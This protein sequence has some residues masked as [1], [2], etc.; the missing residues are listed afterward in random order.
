MPTSDIIR[1]FLLSVRFQIDEAGDRKFRDS[2]KRQEDAAV[3]TKK[4]HDELERSVKNLGLTATATAAT[5]AAGL[6]AV[7]KNYEQLYYVARRTGTAAED[8]TK[9]QFGFQQI[10][11][12]AGDASGLIVTLSNAIKASP[13][14]AGVFEGISGDRIRDAA[15]NIRITTQALEDFFT[16]LRNISPAVRASLASLFGIPQ[17]ELE[18]IIAS[19]DD[20]KKAISDATD[21]YR[22][23][24]VDQDKFLSDSRTITNDLKKIW[25]EVDIVWI[26][27]FEK[28]FPVADRLLKTIDQLL[29]EYL[30]FGTQHPLLAVSA[31]A[32]A[33]AIGLG[34]VLKIAQTIVSTL[35]RIV[36]PGA[37]GGAIGRL[38]PGLPGVIGAPLALGAG[39]ATFLAP[40][41]AGNQGELDAEAR[42][43]AEARRRAGVG[44]VFGPPVPPGFNR[45]PLPG[46]LNYLSG[47]K[48][49][50]Q[51]GV[52]PI[53]AHAGEMVLPRN[54]SEGLQQTYGLGGDFMKRSAEASENLEKELY[55]WLHGSAIFAPRVV[56]TDPS[57]APAGLST[58][59]DLLT[60]MLQSPIG[61]PG[62]ELVPGG[63]ADKLTAISGPMATG[64]LGAIEHFESGG[65]NVF[66]YMYD[67]LHTASG[68][69]QITNST[70]RRYAPLVTGALERGTAAINYSFETQ[71]DVADQILKHEGVGPWANY[72]SRLRA[73]LGG[74]YT[75]IRYG[76]RT[77]NLTLNNTTNIH[78]GDPAEITAR[79]TRTNARLAAD[80]LRN[81]QLL[82]Y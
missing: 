77:A 48:H 7:A 18:R 75:G 19:L 78:G 80:T 63:A 6:V 60:Q 81:S 73:Y 42:L 68:Y 8:L 64:L 20:W 38:V 37:G 53:G 32:A 79:L 71:R 54:I 36:I 34:G 26:Q 69:F 23:A 16:N 10:G 21:L 2:L 14:L 57:G 44:E 12:S 40:S 4:F 17:D 45:P 49:F 55:S 46:F 22:K 3:R 39:A 52:V 43:F 1:E 31:D 25:T 35:A 70:W 62:H 66:N 50:Q 47:V 82:M 51:G 67:A 24:G 33:L 28:V 65:R 74:D 72:N 27:A 41:Q 56:P 29:Q 5:F 13:G 15:G 11:L 9:L 58:L 61:G 30:K 59:V 76:D